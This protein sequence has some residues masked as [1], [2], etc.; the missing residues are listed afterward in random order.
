MI[1]LS[2]Q[3]LK[4]AAMLD[5]VPVLRGL[6]AWLL[7]IKKEGQKI[8][9]EER[10]LFKRLYLDNKEKLEKGKAKLQRE[11]GFT[12]DV[13]AY[14]SGALLQAGS[15]TTAT[16]LIGFVQAMVIFPEVAKAAQAQLD[17]ICGDRMPDLD[18]WDKLPYIR[19][20]AK[21]SLRWMP[22]F[23]LGIPHAV[24]Q[25]DV[26]GEY[27]IPKDATVIINV[28]SVH[29]DPRRHPDPRKF[30][31]LRYIDDELSSN[32]SANS[33]DATQ[34]DHFVFGAGRRR[35]Q[36]MHIADRS[37][38]LAIS[39]MLWAFDFKRAVD[40]QTGREIVPDMDDVVDGMVS[41]P[42]PFKANIVSRS[43]SRAQSIRDEW[44]TAST[45][46]DPETLE[47]KTLPE[48]LRKSC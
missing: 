34:R 17:A 43:Q 41:L 27:H 7:P 13:A 6:P 36:G 1:R 9:R 42:K 46:L 22:G 30:D 38:F 4:T 48:G 47:W 10:R 8:H 29:Q 40:P 32:D 14:I 24:T 39:R 23:F 20:C 21:E 5:L 15:E 26:Y 2:D 11:E 3:I 35:C 16:I 28:W 19:A 25:D 18:D 33:P 44:A 12:D 45:L 31:P 37:I